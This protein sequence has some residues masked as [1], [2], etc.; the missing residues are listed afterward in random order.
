MSWP[1]CGRWMS[2]PQSSSVSGPRMVLRTYGWQTLAKPIVAPKFAR[3]SEHRR[4]LLDLAA[5]AIH[6]N[7]GMLRES[8][9]LLPRLDG[10]V[11]REARVIHRVV[12]VRKHE[13][14]PN[15][16]SQFIAESVKRIPLISHRA[17]NAHH[18]HTSITGQCELVPQGLRR[19]RMSEDIANGP[20]GTA[21]VDRFSVHTKR[22]SWNAL[23]LKSAK[24][25]S[26]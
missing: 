19:A 4:L 7:T 17:T 21:T 5:A 20:A 26:L 11:L 6:S 23:D 8:V 13:V 2:N 25:D 12:H 16:D 1:I 9:K 18:V 24:S 14:L 3:H 15:Q 22:E 10:N